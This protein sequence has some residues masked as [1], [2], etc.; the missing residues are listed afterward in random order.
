MAIV[1]GACQ[2]DNGTEGTRTAEGAKTDK[3]VETASGLE[4]QD[5]VVGTGA[6]PE[7]GQVAVVHY[8]G[9]LTN[10]KKFDSSLDRGR[11]FEFPV[12]RGRVIKGWDEGVAT[13]KSGGK[14]KLWIPANLAYGSRGFG[15]VIPPN[16]ELVFEIELL[17]VK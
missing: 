16:S 4:Y 2:S 3:K 13:M 15:N 6:S 10:G 12:G 5:L 9:W 8:T 1:A 11:P 14:R 17:E 7:P